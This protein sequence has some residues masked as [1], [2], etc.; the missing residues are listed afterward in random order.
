MVVFTTA[1]KIIANVA[2]F[3]MRQL[4]ALTPPSANAETV[5]GSRR[6]SN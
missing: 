3:R 6:V 5:C 2:N 4:V 1:Y